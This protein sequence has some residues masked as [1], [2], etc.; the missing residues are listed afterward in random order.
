MNKNYIKKQH[1]VSGKI[2]VR[3]NILIIPK[4]DKERDEG[5]YQCAAANQHGTS[6]STGQLKVICKYSQLSIS[7][8]RISRILCNS[9]RLSESIIHF[10]CFLQ[11]YTGVED[12]FTSPN[13]PKCKLIWTSGNLNL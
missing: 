2:E 5:M 3:R 11:P 12:F 8:T 7:R 9:K 6:Y 4:I 1:V 13:Y 10:D